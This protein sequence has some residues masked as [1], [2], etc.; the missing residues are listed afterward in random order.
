[1]A[2]L[3]LKRSKEAIAIYD[4]PLEVKTDEA[5]YNLGVVLIK[6]GQFEE[7]IASFNKVLEIQPHFYEIWYNR[8]TALLKLGRLDEA[9]SSFNKAIKLNPN[10]H[11]VWNNQG[12]AL[13]ELERLD[14]AISSFDKATQIK[15]DSY[16]IWYN[17]GI[18][19]GK[20]GRLEEAL[21]SYDKVIEFNPDDRDAWY[22]RGSAL[23]NLGRIDEALASFDKAIEFNPEDHDAWYNRGSALGKLGRYDEA[24]ASFD[25]ATELK[26]NDYEAWYS[27][28]IALRDLGRFKEAIASFDKALEF[29]PDYYQA[30]YNR[31]NALVMVDLGFL[32]EALA[33]YNKAVEFK[34]DYHEAWNSRGYVLLKLGRIDEA[35]ASFDKA[36]EFK[37]DKVEAFYN[38]AGCYALQGNV[39]QAL[40]NLQQA[41]KLSPEQ[42]REMAKFYPDFNGIRQDERFQALIQTESDP[43]EGEIREVRHNVSWEEFENILDEMGDNR[44]AR[45]AY[46]QGTLEITMPSKPHEYYKEIIGDLIK[47][48]ADELLEIECEPFGSTLWKRK[49]WLKGAEPDNCFYIQSLPSVQGKLLDIDLSND[50]PP[51]LILEVDF[52]SPSVDKLLLYARLG[53]PEVWRYNKKVL[54]IYQL[55][56]GKYN[57]TDT[58]LTFPVLPFK[59]I[60]SLIDQN[61]AEGRSAIRRAF[62]AWVKHYIPDAEELEDYLDLRDALLAEADPENQEQIPWEQVKQE[63]GL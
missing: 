58:S 59:G 4:E 61:I 53:V 36:L 50:P 33:S 15:A 12:S 52:T 54:N 6:L 32:N 40:K 29:K 10:S 60:P 27:R 5:W 1:M 42:C 7:A 23:G 49:G 3:L 20:L 51:D 16:Q 34:P 25:K 55:K 39:E 11:E 57:E 44:A 38:K 35:L 48:L 21:A 28:G 47:Y 13:L 43:E 14:E 37:P 46:D 62:R 30:W 41:I 8:G 56:D 2:T 18:A 17:R 26:P 63:L 45:L 9:I 22:N 19:L 24:I 31:G